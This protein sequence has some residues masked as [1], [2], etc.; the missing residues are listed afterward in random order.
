MNYRRKKCFK[1]SFSTRLSGT[2]PI[3][4]RSDIHNNESAGVD[5]TGISQ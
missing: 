4:S 2:E 1:D 5:N 3:N